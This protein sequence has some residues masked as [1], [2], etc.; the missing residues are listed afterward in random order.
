MTDALTEKPGGK[1]ATRRALT[2]GDGVDDPGAAFFNA[3]GKARIGL[4]LALFRMLAVYLPLAALL[5]GALAPGAATDFGV[6]GVFIAACAANA[7][8]GVAAT[9]WV[10]ISARFWFWAPKSAVI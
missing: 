6:V 1:K 4:V 2:T 5:S 7:L 9:I 8:A 3:V 10:G